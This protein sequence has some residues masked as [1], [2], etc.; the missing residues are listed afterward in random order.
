MF[1]KKDFINVDRKYFKV[2]NET[3]YH[4]TLKSKNT[5]HTWDIE[6]RENPTGR[7]LIVNHKHKDSDPFHEQPWFHPR[8]IEEAQELIKS[9]DAWQ[10]EGRPNN[11]GLVSHS[12][13]FSLHSCYHPNI[14]IT[15]F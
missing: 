1:E 15:R 2:I 9:H 6:C 13:V 7:S 11:S 12:C 14:N 5:G 4:L 3:A 8:S 10:I